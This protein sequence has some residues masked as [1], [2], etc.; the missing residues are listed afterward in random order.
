MITWYFI[1]VFLFNQL[2]KSP[3]VSAKWK[4]RKEALETILPYAKS[5]KLDGT[6]RYGELMSALAKVSLLF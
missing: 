3:Q 4:E 1:M 2:K 5:I 6:A